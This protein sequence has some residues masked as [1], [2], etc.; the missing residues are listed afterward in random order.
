MADSPI[1]LAMR[2]LKENAKR[3]YQTTLDQFAPTA[4][5][6][7]H[8]NQTTLPEHGI[9]TEGADVS[10]KLREIPKVTPKKTTPVPVEPDTGQTTLDNNE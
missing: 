8:V 3:D 5:F 10:T 9:S 7:P 2:V 1:D 6:R 4:G